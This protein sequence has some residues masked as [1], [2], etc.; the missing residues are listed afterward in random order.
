MEKRFFLALAL[1]ITVFLLW[2]H[3]F[4]PVPPDPVQPVNDAGSISETTP[5]AGVQVTDVPVAQQEIPDVSD[6]MTGVENTESFDT[7]PVPEK[8]RIHI[9]TDFVIAEID[10]TGG[11]ITSWRLKDYLGVEEQPIE[12]ISPDDPLF[13]PGDIRLNG[14]MDFTHT[15]FAANIDGDSHVLD[16]NKPTLDIELTAQLPSGEYLKKTM[17]FHFDKYMVDLEMTLTNRGLNNIAGRIEYL[18]PDRLVEPLENSA[19]NRY[20]RKGP[21][22]WDGHS[23]ENPKVDKIQ[24]QVQFPGVRWAAIQE[25]YFFSCIA[26][27]SHL[28]T[29]FIEP[30][31][32][33]PQSQKPETA[34]PGIIME[35][36]SLAPG[37]SVVQKV[38]ILIGPKK[39]DMLRNLDLG[40][41]NIVN[42]GWI[43]I[44]GKFF[45]Y[46]L[47]GSVGYLK[48]Y[49]VGI[50]LITIGVK[51]LLFPLSHKQMQSMKKMQ[52]IQ[53]QMKAIQ[54]KYR[55]EPQKQQQEL[56]MLYKKHG[57][58]PMGGCLPM[59]IQ[60]PVF[61]A[62]YQV[63]MN[64]IEMRG[65]SFLWVHDLSQPNVIMVIIMGISMVVQQKMTP[66]AGDPRQARIMM[67]MPIIF[68]AMFWNFPSGLVLY[69]LTNNILTIGQQYVMNRLNAPSDKTEPKMKARVRRR[70]DDKTDSDSA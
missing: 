48:N 45:Y 1:S 8:R 44:L 7:L 61:I 21:V 4:A 40:V 65:A 35:A 58:N 57:V 46:I 13:Y 22:F 26:P 9:E 39:Y 14:R 11:R 28:A 25:S 17:T 52:A 70:L 31:H 19:T 59:L 56:G 38:I 16:E 2:S 64:L 42:F 18:L 6:A 51:L 23:R 33:N 67:M 41:E 36:Q 50:I 62:L 55:K 69:W 10:T 68:T 49:G 37:D 63:L 15:T 54:E 20:I 30:G 53:P 27:L 3:F 29:G 32:R 47:I 12:L 66:V 5:T 60:F 24:T 34:V 43:E